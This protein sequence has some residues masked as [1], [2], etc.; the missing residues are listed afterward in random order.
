LV[1]RRGDRVLP[2]SKSLESATGTWGAMGAYVT[3]HAECGDLTQ[4]ARNTAVFKVER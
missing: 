2:G 4:G 1:K 3:L